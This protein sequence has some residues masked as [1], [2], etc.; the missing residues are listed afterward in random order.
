MDIHRHRLCIAFLLFKQESV[1]PEQSSHIANL[2]VRHVQFDA[3]F[4][5]QY[6]QQ[7]L[8]Y[9]WTLCPQQVSLHMRNCVF[10][11]AL[12]DSDPSKCI[13][14][15]SYQNCLSTLYAS[16]TQLENPDKHLISTNKR[17]KVL[18]NFK[19][20]CQACCFDKYFTITSTLGLISC[21]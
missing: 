13:C 7:A 18:C 10:L 1:V 17:Q 15:I 14:L 16:H 5:S 3:H 12:Q 4:S 2:Q 19:I 21:L 8:W 6:I 20:L 9:S 11:L